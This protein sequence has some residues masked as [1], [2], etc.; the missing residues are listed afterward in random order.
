MSKEILY[1]VR[2][3]M[4]AVDNRNFLYI[5]TFKQN[6]SIFMPM[7]VLALIGGALLM[8]A[9][10]RFGIIEFIGSFFFM[11]CIV[12]LVLILKIELRHMRRVKDDDTGVFGNMT[13]ISFYEDYL[14]METTMAKGVSKLNY[15]DFYGLIETRN[16]YI[17][18]YTKAM[19]T[20]LR[21][22]DM[23]EIDASEFKRF[24]TEK[25]KDKYRKL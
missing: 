16:Y 20:M 14:A 23:K 12:F 4:E 17:F 5:R 10:K 9:M 21:K 13:D 25:F 19:A 11:F 6:S 8:F 3:T 15:K 18:Y 1:K 7:A 2:T 22:K 24:I